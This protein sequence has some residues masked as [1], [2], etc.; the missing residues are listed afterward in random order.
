[1]PINLNQPNGADSQCALNRTGTLC[2]ICK[3]GLSLS[4]GSSRCLKCPTYWPAQFVAITIFA[5]LAGIGLVVVALWLNI[6]VAVGTL[7]G[8][9]FYTNIIAANKVVLLPYP[10]PNFIIVFISWL[11]LELGID[12][13]FID[14]MDT[15]IKTW[16][17][18]AFPIYII[19][20]VILLI[21]ISQHSSRLSKLIAKRNPVAALAL[22]I[23]MSYGK[24]FHVVLLAQ[25]FSYAVLTY[26]DNT[27]N[28]GNFEAAVDIC[29]S[30]DRM[31]RKIHMQLYLCMCVH[32]LFYVHVCVHG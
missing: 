2:G 15:Y 9:L 10:E 31:V 21:V 29:I 23:L 4:L 30:A 22:L 32:D 1:M 12:V 26:P 11:N 6:T 24:L 8:L 13:C 28:V 5:I 18:L 25:P 16:L 3:P 27:K 14:G 20:L 17:Q 7:N 19:L